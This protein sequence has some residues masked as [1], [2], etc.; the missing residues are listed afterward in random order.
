VGTIGAPGGKGGTKPQGAV[1]E[2]AE[3]YAVCDVAEV[4]IWSRF[5]TR[6]KGERRKTVIAEAGSTTRRKTRTTS[7]GVRGFPRHA[8]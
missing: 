2:D 6:G 7:A 8:R 5:I 3:Q 1:A 4:T